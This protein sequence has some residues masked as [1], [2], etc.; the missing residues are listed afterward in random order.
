MGKLCLV[1][2]LLAAAAA[3][4]VGCVQDR[5]LE[6]FD[7]VLAGASDSRL[8]IRGVADLSDSDRLAEVEGMA[9]APGWEDELVE[10]VDAGTDW[11]EVSDVE[12]V[13]VSDCGGKECGPDGC[14]GSCGVCAPGYSCGQGDDGGVCVVDCV[15]WCQDKE[16]GM[17]GP[18]GECPCGECGEPGHQCMDVICT[19]ENKCEEVP[20]TGDSCDDGNPC[21]GSDT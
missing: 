17:A 7:F 18:Q 9:D 21:T 1:G 4:A 11:V 6:Q 16:C 12:V 13:C 20:N 19:Q 5:P 8:D 15:E 10:S 3:F 2:P 14:G